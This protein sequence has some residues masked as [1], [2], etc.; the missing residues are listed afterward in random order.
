MKI[1]TW[2]VNGIRACSKKGLVEFLDQSKP[3]IFCVQET[4]A[5]P[6]QVE[7]AIREL[8]YPASF[9][10]SAVRKGYSGVA[11]FSNVVPISNT[12][13]FGYPE[14]QSEGRTLIT[15]FKDFRLYN[16]YF[17]NGGSGEERH[18]FK[19]IFLRNLNA[20]LK[21]VLSEGRQVIVVGDY[22]V[23][24]QN[25]D[26]YDPVK[27][28]KD[29]GFLPEERQWFD[30]FLELGF[31]DVFR[32]LYPNQPDRYSWWSYRELARARNL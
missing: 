19:Q 31:V 5:H 10:S 27:F 13:T 28:S 14:Y 9:W 17:P 29:S 12:D 20:H 16:I 26:V 25:Q 3:N 32:K 23:A 24:H 2:N 4:K 18:D 1:I 21:S 11:T 22:N 15:D 8:G 7:P 30:S 6:E